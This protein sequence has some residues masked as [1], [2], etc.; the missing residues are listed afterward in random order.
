MDVDTKFGSVWIPELD[1]VIFAR[2][3][4]NTGIVIGPK[5]YDAY[6]AG[7]AYDQY[8]VGWDPKSARITL[9]EH[10]GAWEFICFQ[11]PKSSYAKTSICMYK[12]PMDADSTY[13]R[14]RQGLVSGSGSCRFGIFFGSGGKTRQSGRVRT[15]RL[16]VLDASKVLAGSYE[17]VIRRAAAT[18]TSLAQK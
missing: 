1:G 16:S 3:G 5:F 4:D 12:G 13:Y 17:G 8:V 7:V 14:N 11:D 2:T 15:A 18:G 10:D 9:V 6:D